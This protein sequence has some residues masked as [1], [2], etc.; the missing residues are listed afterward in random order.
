MM[1]L[2]PAEWDALWLSV[3]VALAAVLISLPFGVG[4]AWAL[5][6]KQFPGKAIFETV[7]NLPLVLPPVVTGYFLLV[8]FGRNGFVGGWLS[9]WF[10]LE[11]VF[12][13]KGAALASAVVAFPLMVRSMR[14]AFTTV[15]AR[16]E[17]AA[18]TLGA[19]AWDT[20]F[21]VTLPLAWHGLIAGVVLAF[22]RSLGEFGATIMIAGNIRGETQT[23]PL[24]IY[25]QIN[26]P[27]GF[28]Q[29]R[30][31]LV[32]SVLLSLAALAAS[33]WLLRREQRQVGVLPV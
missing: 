12:N 18:R 33:E 31:V 10:G 6:R 13:W 9:N 2:T 27:G 19:N 15:D 14:V 16:L 3:Q 30:G 5:A 20:F 28:E 7:L 24:Y 22:A 32:V 8:T 26:T 11:F 4:C 25:D 1:G 29:T 17:N 23:V 21:S